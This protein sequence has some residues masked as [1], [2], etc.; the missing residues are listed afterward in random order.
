MPFTRGTKN[1]NREGG[2]VQ[3][4]KNSNSSHTWPQGDVDNAAQALRYR[5]QIVLPVN[6]KSLPA[7]LIYLGRLLWTAA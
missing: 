1:S 7:S 2:L 5:S 3:R 6:M 4:M